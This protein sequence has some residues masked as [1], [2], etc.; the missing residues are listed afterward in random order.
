MDP[1]LLSD[2]DAD[3]VGTKDT[4]NHVRNLERAERTLDD[5]Q[6]KQIM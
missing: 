2:A 1:W 3:L 4:T 5:V 6:F